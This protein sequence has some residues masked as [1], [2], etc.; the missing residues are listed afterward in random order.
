VFPLSPHVLDLSLVNVLGFLSVI[1]AV[2]FAMPQLLKL[3]RGGSTAGLSLESLANSTISLTGW[4]IYGFGHGNAWVILASIAGI[5]ATVATLV[6]AVRAGHRLSP[7]LPI[8][9]AGL[10]AVTALI[11]HVLGSALVDVALGCSILWFVV[12]AALTAWRSTDVSGLAAQTWLILAAD[13]SVFGLYGVAADVAADRVYAVTSIAG[14]AVILA[15]IAVARQVASSAEMANEIANGVPNQI[16]NEM[17]N[18]V[19]TCAAT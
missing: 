17:A 13:G 16:A 2:W 4:T 11:D 18:E 6:I 7:Q 12:P 9:W 10:L 15:R 5:P 8:V 14:A 19:A 1:L 3:R